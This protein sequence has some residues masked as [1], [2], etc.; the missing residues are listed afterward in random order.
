MSNERN[1]KT[2]KAISY[3]ISHYLTSNK[4]KK[5]DFAKMIG[6]TRPTVKRWIDCDC[7][8]ELDQFPI[9]CEILN[10]SIYEFIGVEDPNKLNDDEK[11]ILELYVSNM[12]FRHLVDRYR[13]EESFRNTID[14]I[15]EL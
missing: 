6:V 11:E 13:S 3:N 1:L 14:K 10:I 9:I 4:I 7:I 5:T 12:N 8:P 2:K 15:I